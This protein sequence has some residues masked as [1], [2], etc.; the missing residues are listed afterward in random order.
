MKRGSLWDKQPP[1]YTSWESKSWFLADA[2]MA[3]P[4]GWDLR[5]SFSCP[6]SV[7]VSVLGKG[8]QERHPPGV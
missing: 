6:G 7:P 3:V 2:S 1:Y 5:V 4:S 8:E